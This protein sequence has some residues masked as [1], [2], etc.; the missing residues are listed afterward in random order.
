MKSSIALVSCELK[1]EMSLNVPTCRSGSTSRWTGARGLMSRMA[2][3]PSIAL[4][5]S[6]SRYRR[7]NRQSSW[8]GSEDPLLHDRSRA[9]ADQVTDGR[10]DEPRRV[11][12]AVAAARSV[13]EH[14]VLGTE[15]RAP[16]GAAGGDG[17]GA[18]PGAALALRGGGHGVLGGGGGAGPRRVREDV[19]LRDPGPLHRL[20]RPGE[21]GL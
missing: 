10:V 12:A 16:V 5:W 8:S 18:Q 4:T 7:Q 19:H 13:D 1:A 2:T 20:E 17:A 11:V 21:C 6:P 9:D 3:K 15:L 14:L